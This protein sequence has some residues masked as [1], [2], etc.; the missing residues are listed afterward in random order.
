MSAARLSPLTEFSRE[1]RRAIIGV[2][3]DIDDTLTHEGALPG[4]SLVALERLRAAGLKVI[5]VTGRPAG[6][7]ARISASDL[8]AN[9]I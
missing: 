3:A 6:W 1:H 2:L 9:F 5:P 8:F 4:A 7:C